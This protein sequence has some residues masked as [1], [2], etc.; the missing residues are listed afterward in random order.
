MKRVILLLLQFFVT[1]ECAN[2]LIVYENARRS[3]QIW[4]GELA[5]ALIDQGHNITMG[6]SFSKAI[7]ESEQYHPITFE[8]KINYELKSEF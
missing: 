8:G 3:H 5:K 2:I 1:N 7:D 4:I 6:G